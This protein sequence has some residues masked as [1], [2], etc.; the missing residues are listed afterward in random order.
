MTHFI[1]NAVEKNFLYISDKVEPVA[2]QA[3]ILLAKTI[4]KVVFRVQF[5][6]TDSRNEKSI[7]IKRVSKAL[8]LD[9][10]GTWVISTLTRE[11]DLKT[12]GLE[13]IDEF[14]DLV[15]NESNVFKAF[16]GTWE[17]LKINFE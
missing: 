17:I 1:I 3:L 12:K 5:F 15:K 13:L 10:L 16:K 8:D 14:Y 9:S 4:S 6:F 11:K 7:L 2:Q